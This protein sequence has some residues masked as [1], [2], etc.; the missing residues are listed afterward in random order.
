MTL[1]VAYLIDSL[2]VGGSERSL[3]EM[4][5]H[6]VEAGVEPRV[7]VLSEPADDASDHVHTTADCQCQ[8]PNCENCHGRRK[9][10]PPSYYVMAVDADIYQ[11]MF[12]EV[13][14]SMNMPCKLFYCGHHED[15]DYPSIGIA[16][17]GVTVL[18]LVMLWIT[19]M[20]DG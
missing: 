2:G 17:A 9:P 15:V 6:L 16:V 5:P 12:D 19:M 13:A 8:C 20:V 14:E 11:R 7:F 10:L 3:V 18:F 4:L 1:R